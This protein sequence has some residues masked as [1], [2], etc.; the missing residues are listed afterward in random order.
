MSW[1]DVPDNADAI[2]RGGTD[3]AGDHRFVDVRTA[4]DEME[5][6]GCNADQTGDNILPWAMAVSKST[7]IVTRLELKTKI[8][9]RTQEMRNRMWNHRAAEGET[10]AEVGQHQAAAGTEPK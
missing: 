1:H 9:L 10:E 8:I 5:V 4:K 7:A 3:L 2:G 6:V